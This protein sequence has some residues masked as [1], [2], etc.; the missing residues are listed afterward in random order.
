[1]ERTK[2]AQT[3]GKIWWK[4]TGG[5][6]LRFNHK[7]IK[8]N[9]RFKARPDEI[10]ASFRDVIIPL[11]DLGDVE[12]QA[13]PV[14]AVKTEYTIKPRGKSKSLFD[15]VYPAGKEENGETIWKSINEKPLTKDI[16]E[17]LV[18]DLSKK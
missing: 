1:M 13:A 15:V 17:K 11:E 10:P 18:K 14:E 6:S 7:I 4:K 12:K 16:A 2:Q 9:E 8:P 3:D 5:G